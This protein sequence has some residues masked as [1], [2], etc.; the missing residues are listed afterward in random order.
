MTKVY[1][2]LGKECQIS[3]LLPWGR[4][5]V[6]CLMLCC[7]I[8]EKRVI[9]LSNDVTIGGGNAPSRANYH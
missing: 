8:N 4:V 7:F 1:L 2:L 3:F 9:F 6:D 5:H